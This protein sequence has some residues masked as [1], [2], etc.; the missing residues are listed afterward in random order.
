MGNNCKIQL[1][2]L[3]GLATLLAMVIFYLRCIKDTK[4]N[5]QNKELEEIISIT[6]D[7]Y[8]TGKTT[9]NNNNKE[10]FI[11]SGVDGAFY[12]EKTNAL[13]GDSIYSNQMIQNG[14]NWKNVVDV[15]KEQNI[16]SD[17]TNILGAGNGNGFEEAYK[18]QRKLAEAWDSVRNGYMPQEE[19]EK[20]AKVINTTTSP[21]SDTSLLNRGNQ[22]RGKMN[23]L[24]NKLI[25]VID[26]KYMDERSKN[27][28][29]YKANTVVHA[30]GYDIDTNNIGNEL[31][32]THFAKYISNNQGQRKIT[33]AGASTNGLKIV[34]T[35]DGYYESPN[36][37]RIDK[38]KSN[39]NKEPFT[40]NI[41]KGHNIVDNTTEGGKWV[42]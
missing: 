9:E 21:Q 12:N 6:E 14:K 33:S 3:I 41:P 17:G 4:E 40:N 26:E 1:S 35:Q 11:S 42:I 29:I 38:F 27:R 34:E 15:A 37:E 2:I 36:K 24:P 23:I 25:C 39:L 13:Q 8:D 30:Q 16:A 10:G 19:Y 20:L 28:D 32:D 7:N 22:N 31:S 18:S 5:K